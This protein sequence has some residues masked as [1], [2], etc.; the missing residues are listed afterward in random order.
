MRHLETGC[1]KHVLV[2]G[3]RTPQPPYR[4]GGQASSSRSAALLLTHPQGTNSDA[5]APVRPDS[6]PPRRPPLL[7]FARRSRAL[8][9]Q[10][11][12]ANPVWR[13]ST[14]G[15]GVGGLAQDL[16]YKGDSHDNRETRGLSGDRRHGA[17]WGL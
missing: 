12:G 5:S 9:P 3:L 1:A 13:C 17:Q 8:L 15:P 16:L 10:V 2:S 11:A 14:V 4:E 7:C 6:L